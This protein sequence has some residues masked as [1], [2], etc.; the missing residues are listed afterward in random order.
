MKAAYAN[1]VLSAFE[2]AGH[3]PF[4][5][6][7]GTSAGGALA[8]W[9]SAR[10]AIYAEATWAY[11]ADPRILSYRRWLLRRGALLDH[12]ALLDI[13]YVH[14][15]PIDQSALRR[16]AWPVVVTAA[17]IHSGQ[18]RYVDLRREPDL[19]A[20]LKA[21]GRLPFASG[22]PVVID[23]RAYLDGGIVDPIPVQK[24]VADGARDVTVILNTPTGR[25]K[26]D[27]V[28]LARAT[29]R[30]FPRLRDGLLHHQ[31]YKA[32]AWA[33]IAQPPDGVTMRLIRPRRGTRLH[34]LTRNLAVI[35]AGLEQGRADGRRFLAGDHQEAQRPNV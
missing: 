6:V 25:R 33:F 1:G 23:G 26:A 30:R 21:T 4:D 24:A 10:Q 29:A 3:H 22:E 35:R 17:D 9:Y 8:A 34:R 16:C 20:W 12:E 32:K 13:V 19:I 31:A 14:E 7:Y 2:E 15:H 27:N 5:A 11:A 18:A 28:V